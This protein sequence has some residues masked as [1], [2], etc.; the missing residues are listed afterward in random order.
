MMILNGGKMKKKMMMDLE[1]L[2]SHKLKRVLKR[3]KNRRKELE[4]RKI[5]ISKDLETLDNLWGS[6]THP[7][8]ILTLKT[9]VNP[10]KANRGKR[11]KAMKIHHRMASTLVSLIKLKLKERMIRNKKSRAKTKIRMAMMASASVI[12][13]SK[14]KKRIIRV[15]IMKAST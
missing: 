11:K 14:G 13:S 4:I 7:K 3:S 5:K 8:V 12:L 15:K 6:K 1:I 10:H 9:L 2:I